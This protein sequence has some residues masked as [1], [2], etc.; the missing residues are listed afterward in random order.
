MNCAENRLL[1]LGFLT[2]EL[3]ACRILGQ[4]D[5]AMDVDEE[6]VTMILRARVFP[7]YFARLLHEIV[8]KLVNCSRGLNL[9]IY[10]EFS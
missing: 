5:E 10:R 3:Q 1:L 6:E 9:L 7:D 2:S 4:D 8:T